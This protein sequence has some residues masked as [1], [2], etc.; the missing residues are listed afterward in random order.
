MRRLL[1]RAQRSQQNGQSLVEFALVLPLLMVV[2]FVTIEVALVFVTYYSETRMAR[3]SARW[4]AIRSSR[5][6]DTQF[7]DHVQATMLPGLV[8]GTHVTQQLGTTAVDSIEQVG[9]MTIKFT[10]CVW[11]G[12]VCTHPKRAPGQTLY[13]EM[14]YDVGSL[15]FLPSTFRFGNLTVK[16]PTQLPPYKVSVMVE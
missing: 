7:A 3:E 10:P 16:V 11:D 6:T 15:I 1:K 8:N 2:I 13:V 4:L 5:T 9:N 12:T 14:T